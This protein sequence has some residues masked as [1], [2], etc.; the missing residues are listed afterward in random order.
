MEDEANGALHAF[1]LRAWTALHRYA[2]QLP[3]RL[4]TAHALNASS[5]SRDSPGRGA[6]RS[7]VVEVDR[8][9]QVEDV[10]TVLETQ[11]SGRTQVVAIHLERKRSS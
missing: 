9:D 2:S 10:R 7:M 8:E 11:T 4:F 5:R 3:S 6:L 1:L